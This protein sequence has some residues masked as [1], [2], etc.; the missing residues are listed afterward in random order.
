L[1][2]YLYAGVNP[3]NAIDPSGE[4]ALIEYVKIFTLTRVIPFLL[5]PS[6]PF[7]PLYLP[8]FPVRLEKLGAILN[9][10]NLLEFLSMLF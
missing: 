4:V 9:G 7:S 5:R 3:V 8:Y 6:S 1:H 2:D 10:L